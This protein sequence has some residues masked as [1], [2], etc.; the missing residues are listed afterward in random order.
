MKRLIVALVLA[1]TATLLPLSGAFSAGDDGGEVRGRVR[2]RLGELPVKR[3]SQGVRAWLRG[4]ASTWR[5]AQAPA[6]LGPSF[7]SNVDANDPALDLIAGQ[8]E[9]AIGVAGSRVL[10][11]WN[12]AS[13][14]LVTDPPSTL[15]SFTGVGFSSDGGAHFKDLIGPPNPNPQQQWSGDPS[16][17]AVDPNHFFIASLYFPSF[18]VNC[19]RGPSQLTIGLTVATVSGTS[20]GFG[21]PV[22]PI[23]SGNICA[24]RGRHV[25]MLDKEFI[26]YDP[27]TRTLAMSYTRFKFGR[28]SSGLGQVEVVRAT[29]P[30]NPAALS[31]ADFSAPIV[32]WKEEPYCDIEAT[33]VPTPAD[34]CS[35]TNTGAYPTVAPNGDVYVAWERN[36]LSNIFFGDF[37]VYLHVALVPAGAT[38]P[39]VGGPDAPVVITKG[40]VN[41]TADGGV[42]S[43]VGVFISGYTRGYGQDFPRIAVDPVHGQ[44]VFAWNDASLHPLGDIWLR[45]A[46]FGLAT[47]N[48]IRKVNDDNSYALHLLP[49]LS[50]GS[51]GSIRTSWYDRR[52]SGPDSSVTDYMGETRASES[53]NASD[54]LISTGPT[55]WLG[56]STTIGPNFGDY[57]DNATYGTTTYYAWADGRLGIPQP[58]VATHS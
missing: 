53:T 58:F 23:D 8:A 48:P 1:L 28:H 5:R 32:L 15:V 20:V 40:Q 55:D 57:T 33:P 10:V 19:K 44:V 26:A 46:P 21:D 24:R 3:F 35:A 9:T 47:M 4:P 45:T 52:F 14:F 2:D 37:Y 22:V 38:A 13:G 34:R 27:T 12:D 42:K 16:I 51:D 29:V 50:V 11:A 54:F 18:Y 6:A 49:A 41:S 30:T 31:A 7:G 36:W 39:T 17:V 43:M 56:T 25:S